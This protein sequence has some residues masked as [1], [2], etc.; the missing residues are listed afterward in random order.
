[1]MDPVTIVVLGEPT[2][3]A[4]NSN[5]NA[6]GVQVRYRP[7]PA[8]QKNAFASLRAAAQ[9]AMLGQKAQLFDC[10]LRWDMLAERAI[11]QSWSKTKRE[12]AIRGEILPAIRPDLTKILRLAEDAFKSVVYTDDARICEQHNRKRYG[13]QPKLVITVSQA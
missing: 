3:W 5:P 11:P 6:V 1:M 7:I 12:A 8:K 10:P 4:Q 13:V 9:V 2:A